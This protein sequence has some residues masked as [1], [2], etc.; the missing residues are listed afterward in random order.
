M[1]DY[2]ILK[3]NLTVYL[4]IKE[5]DPHAT[6]GW[7]YKHLKYRLEVDGSKLQAMARRAAMNKNG[8]AIDGPFRVVIIKG[9]LE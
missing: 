1:S 6:G 2:G 5:D 3:D 9:D 8:Q 4:P 7:S